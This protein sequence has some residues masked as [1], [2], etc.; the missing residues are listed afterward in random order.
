MSEEGGRNAA[1]FISGYNPNKMDGEK[2]TPRM[3]YTRI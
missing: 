2:T 3:G 1:F